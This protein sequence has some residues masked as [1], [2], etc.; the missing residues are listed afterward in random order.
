MLTV[1]S[2]RLGLV[3]S[4]PD[5]FLCARYNQSSMAFGHGKLV[6]PSL[7]LMGKISIQNGLGFANRFDSSVFQPDNL[8]AVLLKHTA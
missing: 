4:D 3:A 7:M 2:E 1:R 8:V 5:L 6:M